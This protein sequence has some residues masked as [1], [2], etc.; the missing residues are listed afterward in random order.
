MKTSVNYFFL[1]FAAF[2]FASSALC[3]EVDVIYIGSIDTSY[4][5]KDVI[6]TAC[7]LMGVK[8]KS[9]FLAADNRSKIARFFNE[10]HTDTF[11]ISARILPYI[12]YQHFKMTAGKK[13]LILINNHCCPK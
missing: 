10:S 5:E 1:L 12:K 4:Q 7:E 13:I 8:L 9:I 2:F 11:I 6:N 3:D